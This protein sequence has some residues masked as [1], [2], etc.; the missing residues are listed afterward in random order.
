MEKREDAQ[1]DII[2]PQIVDDGV[3]H[4]PTHLSMADLRA[5]RQSSGAAGKQQACGILLVQS[6]SGDGSVWRGLQYFIKWQAVGDSLAFDVDVMLNCKWA[7]VGCF[8]QS[9]VP[10]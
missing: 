1:V 6:F 9:H 4:V 8:F 2:M 10:C 3:E 5:F 7:V